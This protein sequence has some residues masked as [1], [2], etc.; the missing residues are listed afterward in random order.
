LWGALQVDLFAQGPDE[1]ERQQADDLVSLITPVIKG[2][3]T[4]KGFEATVQG[5]RSSAATAI[6]VSTDGA[7]RRDCPDRP[8]LRG[9][10]RHP[11]A[12]T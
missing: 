7:V 2:Y 10:E 12:W 8:D 1:E 5:S 4:D 11:G 6:S 3:L 9:H